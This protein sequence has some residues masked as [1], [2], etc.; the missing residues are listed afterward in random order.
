[1][2][3]CCQDL[4][5]P[6]PQ[7]SFGSYLPHLHQSLGRGLERLKQFLILIMILLIICS[8]STVHRHEPCT[9]SKTKR[10]TIRIMIRMKS[11]REGRELS[12]NHT[13]ERLIQKQNGVLVLP[14]FS[15]SGSVFQT[16]SQNHFFR[17]T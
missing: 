15:R 9:K 2:R 5:P 6:P 16:V 13:H 10:I 11:T 4:P 7:S 1:M 14:G 8:C 3:I 17:L 12:P